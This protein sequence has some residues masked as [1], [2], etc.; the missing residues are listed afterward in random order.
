MKL[1][2]NGYTLSDRMELKKAYYNREDISNLDRAI[3]HLKRN[4]RKYMM[5]VTAIAIAID[6]SGITLGTTLVAATSLDSLQTSLGNQ[7]QTIIELLKFVVKYACLG[8]GLKEMVV[9]ILNGGNMK[10][11]SMSGIQYWLGYLFIQFYPTLFE[12]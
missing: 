10:E 8:M 3:G 1:L 2:V 7:F 9:T 12:M 5:A 4:R 11:A 6:L